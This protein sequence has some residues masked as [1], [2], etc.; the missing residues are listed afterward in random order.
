MAEGAEA[1][2]TA[3]LKPELFAE[4]GL[5]SVSRT[6][7]IAT[8]AVLVLFGF[9]LRVSNLSSEGLSEDELNKL[10][11]VADY[12]EHG[13]TSANGEHPLLMKALL[14]G[15]LV[16]ADKWNSV[17]FLSGQKTISP[18]TA[19]RLPSTVFGALTAILIYLLAAEL[20]GAEVGLIS[21]ALWA[22][23]PMAIGFNR[24]AKEDTF[25]LF[26][27]LLANVFWMRGQRVAESQPDRRPEKYYWATAAAFGAMIASKYVP[28]LLTIS[29]G[30]YWLFQ[31]I[32]ETRWRLGK[33]KML[34]FFGIMSAV[35]IV[36]NPT[37]LFP[38]TWRQMGLFAGQKLIGHDAYEFMG[39]LYSHR[40]TDWLNGIP[41]YFYHVFVA[42]KL[43]FLTVVAFVVGL[44]LLFRRKLGDGRYLILLWLFLWMMIFSFAGGKFTRY[45]TVALPAVLITSA[46]G[47]QFASNWIAR[48]LAALVSADRGPQARGPQR[49]SAAGV[50][51]GSP[52]GVVEWPRVFLRAA[53]A[54][55]VV[56]TA[57]KAAIDAAPHF[58]LY[59]NALGGGAA[60]QGYYFPHDEFYDASVRDV[61]FEIAKRAK[62]G[63]KVASETPGL[64]A[65]YAQ[66]ANRP[67]LVC[68][69]LS[70]PNALKQ[71]VEGDFIIDAPG[72]RYFSNEL[73]TSALKQSSAPAFRV[74]LGPVPS[75]SVYMLD[76]RSLEA[77]VEAARRLPP[78]AKS[79]NQVLVSPAATH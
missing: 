76:K 18:E 36:L 4:R 24:I 29:I 79:V 3:G 15:S 60:K 38:A 1:I 12:R 55:L 43:P 61:M 78:L 56:A 69:L 67:D 5:V 75:A 14:T 73:V 42:V 13:L 19:L 54:L 16:L 20:F 72:R 7:L 52:L 26:F 63:A 70:D 47:V 32:P 71:L 41:W 51:E 27:F 31:R 10:Q 46:I 40:L 30:Y 65:Y 33:K 44:P 9:G 11:A 6:V 37:I 66:R 53:L 77:V 68:V 28:Q 34:M 57:F 22:F 23:D 62:P 17:S 74:S 21:A 59:T 50:E 58:R 64:A 35:F 48:R 45:F 2:I 39:Q 49:R 25:L 8:L